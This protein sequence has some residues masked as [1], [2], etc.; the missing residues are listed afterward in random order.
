MNLPL[1]QTS[2]APLSR[3]FVVLLF[4]MDNFVFLIFIMAQPHGQMLSM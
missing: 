2:L 3:A 4:F 1:K